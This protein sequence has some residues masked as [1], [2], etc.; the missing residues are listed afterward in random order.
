MKKWS[1][2][3]EAQLKELYLS[4]IRIDDIASTLSRGRRSVQER[5]AKLGLSGSRP[6]T[7]TIEKDVTDD[8]QLGYIVGLIAS[9]GN[10]EKVNGRI[11]L[12][13]DHS[14]ESTVLFVADSLVEN[15]L[16][17]MLYYKDSFVRFRAT[18][19]KFRNYL[20]SLGITEAKSKTLS[21]NLTDKTREYRHGFLIG[22][23][24]G[25]GNV[26]LQ[27]GQSILGIATS[28]EIFAK[29]LKLLMEE[30]FQVSP[31][32]Q[33]RASGDSPHFYVYYAG[34]K[35]CYIASKVILYDYVMPR[36]AQTLKYMASY[37]EETGIHK[38]KHNY[39]TKKKI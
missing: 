33:I 4:N 11:S 23:L 14:D 16:G 3:E 29:Q 8:Y 21:I 7:K 39:V 12:S 27:Q 13:L 28:S 35:A 24:C 30:L 19:P 37:A 10:I 18:L 17:S 36:K 25:D 5:L 6:T 9:D 15:T 20:Y 31:K 2:E 34:N 1:A 26:R 32:I 22:V 38:L